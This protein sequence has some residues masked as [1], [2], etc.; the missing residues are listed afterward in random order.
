MHPLRR[1]ALHSGNARHAEQRPGAQQGDC[2]HESHSGQGLHVQHGSEQ[3]LDHTLGARR[4]AAR[5]PQQDWKPYRVWTGQ[6]RG[7]R[8]RTARSEPTVSA[9]GSGSDPSHEYGLHDASVFTC[10]GWYYE[11]HECECRAFHEFDAA[12]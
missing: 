5:F 11:P 12:T 3:I 1:H 10:S 4:G 9:A 7:C 6:C 2:G 8:H